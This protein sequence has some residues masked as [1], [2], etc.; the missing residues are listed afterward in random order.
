MATPKRYRN[1]TEAHFAGIAEGHR[2]LEATA[3]SDEERAHWQLEAERFEQLARLA[4]CDPV[5]ARR[6]YRPTVAFQ[7]PR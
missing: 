4:M 1:D 5:A 2:T 3:E 6:R 7:E